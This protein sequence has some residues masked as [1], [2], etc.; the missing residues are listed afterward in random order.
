M[1]LDYSSELLLLLIDRNLLNSIH[2]KQEKNTKTLLLLCE[3]VL[4]PFLD[5]IFKLTYYFKI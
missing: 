3:N 4:T 2:F 1:Y 5:F